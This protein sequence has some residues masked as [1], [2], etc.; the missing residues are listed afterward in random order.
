ML[1]ENLHLCLQKCMHFLAIAE[2]IPKNKGTGKKQK[3]NYL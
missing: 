2:N 1:P 3:L